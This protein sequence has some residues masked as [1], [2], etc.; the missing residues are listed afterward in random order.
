VLHGGAT[1]NEILD[2]DGAAEVDIEPGLLS[3]CILPAG[4]DVPPVQT[5]WI[6][7]R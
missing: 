2:S 4:R 3:V 5:M 7:S 1:V 6:R